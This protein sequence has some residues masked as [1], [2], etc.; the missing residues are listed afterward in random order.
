MSMGFFGRISPEEFGTFGYK[1]VRAATKRKSDSAPIRV[2]SERLATIGNLWRAMFQKTRCPM[3]PKSAT[4]SAPI[5]QYGDA[6]ATSLRFGI[7][8]EKL[9]KMR[10]HGV[11]PEFRVAGHRT[12]L[13]DWARFETWLAT[14]PRG[15]GGTR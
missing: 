14:L 1:T 3:P 10:L 5:Q 7:G 13:Y 4:K 12:I 8:T 15:G 11:G 9:R 2:Q 6:A